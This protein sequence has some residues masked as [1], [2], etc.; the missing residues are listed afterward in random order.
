LQHLTLSNTNTTDLRGLESANNL[1]KLH[2]T[3]NNITCTIPS[4]IF[5]LTKLEQIY[6]AFNR[7]TGTIPADG[8]Y[9]L[10]KLTDLYLYNN[11]LKGTIPE[12]IRMKNTRLRYLTLGGND[13]TGTQPSSLHELKYL[14]SISVRNLRE[15]MAL[16][17]AGLSG[18][19]LDFQKS[20]FLVEI[21]LNH[22]NLT[23]TN[24]STLL[25]NTKTDGRWI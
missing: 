12:D 22:N 19:L 24:P 13:I 1:T 8:L 2:L 25:K 9:N 6:L 18:P 15:D 21:H 20:K 5:Q 16:G 11:F 17:G 4:C 3:N 14:R 23:G 10:T 7:L